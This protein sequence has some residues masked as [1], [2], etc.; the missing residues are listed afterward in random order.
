MPRKL[1]KG[2]TEYV[3]RTGK[4]LLADFRKIRELEQ[5][6]EIE[7]IGPDCIDWLGAPLRSGDKVFGVI[8]VQSYDPA[9]SHSDHDQEILTYLSQHVSTAIERRQQEEAL[10][11]SEARH[12]SLIESAVYGMYRSTTEGRFLDVN[13]ALVNLLGYSSA[14]ELMAVNIAEDIYVDPDERTEA[15]REY[16]ETGSVEGKE[17]HWRRK[18]GRSITVRLSGSAFKNDRGETGFEMIAEDVSERRL[19]EEQLRQAQKMEA[20][21]RLAGGVAHD[22]NN[23]LTVIKGYSELMLEELDNAHPLRTEVDE[24]KKAADRAASLTRQ[25]LAFSRQQVLAPKVLDLNLIVHNMDKLLRRLLGEEVILTSVLAP[26]LGRVKAD[27]GQVEQVIMNLAVN[28][29]DAMPKG[30]KLTIETSNVD[31]DE[32]YTREHVAVKPGKYVMIAVSDTGMGM[33]EKV[34]ARIFEPFFTTK[35]VGKGTGL[36][37]STVYGIVKQ[38]GG[39]VWVYSE[40]GIGS[41]FKVYLPRVD[42]PLDAG[43]LTRQLITHPG[44]ETV[45]LVEDEEGVR[46]LMRQVLQKHG[47]NVLEARDGG[48]ALVVCERHQGKIELLLTDVVLENMSGQDVAERLLRFRPDMK[49]LYVS[50]Y[51]D[52]AIVKHGVLTAGAAFLQKPFTTE[53][54]AR[55]IRHVLEARLEA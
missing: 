36:G 17:V 15:I 11:V 6:A 7:P 35:E 45:L 2:L 42:A 21:G 10:R 1:R 41:T 34:Q 22:F 46:T 23:L 50:G 13:P 31:L 27:P 30:G 9:I 32:N 8:A 53:A 25:L 33:P 55:K 52:D 51:A 43:S 47:Y 49:V 3:L 4:P 20:V 12:R 54:L 24:I 19:L 29:R 16:F 26:T 40:V 48:E 39:Y 18:D 37:L 44:N 5:A 14:D 28:A 38:S